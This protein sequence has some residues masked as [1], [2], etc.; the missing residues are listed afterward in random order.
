MYR[1]RSLI[2]LVVLLGT[3]PLGADNGAIAVAPV[4]RGLQID[5]DLAD[6]PNDRP[7]IRIAH[8][9][10]GD[11]LRAG[12]SPDLEA[13]ASLA[14]DPDLGVLYVGVQVIDDSIVLRASDQGWRSQDGCD[15][16][17]RTQHR[18]ADKPVSQFVLWGH[19]ADMFGALRTG[20]SI[21]QLRV[22]AQQSA[23]HRD[24]E[25]AIDL[26]AAGIDMYPNTII[27]F[28]IAI[29]D[30]D[31]DGSFT[32]LSWGR[33]TLK[34]SFPD[35]LGDLLLLAED[36]DL[37]PLTGSLSWQDLDEPVS[38]ALINVH[39]PPAIDINLLTDAE[40]NFDLVLPAG[41]YELIPVG[42]Q[43]D[44]R[45]ISLDADHPHLEVTVSP[46]T[47]QTTPALAPTPMP[48]GLGVRQGLWQTFG[49][50]DG[51]PSDVVHAI[52]QD[53]DGNIWLAT[54]RGLVKYDG[55]RFHTYDERHG[56]PTAS[57]LSL[58]EDREGDLWIGMGQGGVCRFDGR[59]F[60]TFT[61]RDGLVDNRV[62]TILQDQ[63]GGYWFGTGAGVS[64]Y[65]GHH[66]TNYTTRAGLVDNDISDLLQVDD[67][68]V[69]ISTGRLTGLS[70]GGGVSRFDGQTFSNLTVADG[71]PHARVLDLF[72]H[73]G[74]MWFATSAGPARMLPDGTI[75]TIGPDALQAQEIYSIVADDHENLW[76]T[77]GSVFGAG[78]GVV[79]FDGTGF[80]RFTSGDG[81]G[82]DRVLCSFVDREGFIWFGT[83]DGGVSRYDGTRMTIFTTEDGLP[84]NDV[85]KLMVDVDGS[86]W[87]ATSGGVARFNGRR[88]APTLT[89]DDGLHTNEIRQTFRADD[90]SLWLATGGFSLTGTG[91]GLVHIDSTG[92]R[93]LNRD[94]GLGSDFVT[95]L[96]QAENGTMWLATADGLIR[97]SAT[98]TVT[99]STQDGLPQNRLSSVLL[100]GQDVWITGRGIT[101]FSEGVFTTY[102]VA[103]GLPAEYWMPAIRDDSGTRWFGGDGSLSRLDGDDFRHYTP[104]DGLP[105]SDVM[106]LAT[107]PD[108]NLWL[109]TTT[110]VSRFD[111]RVFQ[112]LHRRDG[113]P[114]HEVRDVVVD[115]AG[116]AWIATAAGIARYR[117]H[118]GPLQLH[119]ADVVA[120]RGYGPVKSLALPVGQRFLAFEMGTDRLSNRSRTIVYRYRLL[121]HDPDWRQTRVPRVVYRDLWPGHFTFEV[122]AIDRDFNSSPMVR[123]AVQVQSAWHRDPTRWG[124]LLVLGLTLGGAATVGVRR[125]I[126]SRVERTRL[127]RRQMARYRVRDAVWRMQDASDIESVLRAVA[128]S[129]REM[130]VPFDFFGVNVLVDDSADTVEVYTMAATGTWHR[131]SSMVAPNI[132]KFWRG[133]RTVYRSDLDREDLYD[134]RP[135]ILSGLRSVVDIPFSR[136]TLAIS[137]SLPEA[138]SSADLTTLEELARVLEEGFHRLSDLESIQQR[139]REVG[140]AEKRLT[141][142]ERVR[143]VIWGLDD[144]RAPTDLVTVVNDCLHELGVEFDVC[145]VNVIESQ[146]PPRVR[147]YET[148]Q[149][150]SVEPTVEDGTPAARIIVDFW[151][152]QAVAY[153]RDL[154]DDDPHGEVAAHAA[155]GITDPPRSILDV[156]FSHGTL[157][158]NNRSANGFSEQ[159]QSNVTLLASL[160]SDGFRRLADLQ[161]LEAQSAAEKA[162]RLTAE[163]ANRTK[164]V[165]LANMSHEI[166]TPMNAILGYAQILQDD[167]RLDPGQRKGLNTIEKSGN[168]LL[169][170]INDV[171]DISKIE[172]GREEMHVVP[173][174]LSSLIETTA[175]MFEVRCRQKGLRWMLETDHLPEARVRGDE[176]KLR[177]VLINLL[178]NAVKFTTQGQILLRVMHVPDADSIRFEV[179]DTGRGIPAD[180]H[181]AIFEAFH[182][183]SA[184]VMEGGTGLG[185]AISRR[186]VAL[187]GGELL[188]ESEEG[189]GA[190]FRFELSLPT[191][192]GDGEMD[193]L[194]WDRVLRL[195][196]GQSVKALVVDDVDTNRDVLSQML[197]RIGVD[198]RMAASGQQALD[199]A[200][201]DI[202]DIVFMD[203]R[204]PEMGGVET[205]RHL[206]QRHGPR[207][208]KIIAVTASVLEHQ[209]EEYLREG[210]DGFV[211][212]PLSAG[213]VYAALHQHLGVILE[214]DE[215]DPR[216]SQDAG[217][218]D[219]RLP[220]RVS[221]ALQEAIESHSVTE[222]RRQ[223]EGL[224]H[225]GDA[226]RRLAAHLTDLSRQ[227]DLDAIEQV[228]ARLPA[229][230]STDDLADD[231]T[232]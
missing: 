37:L 63:E 67:G 101:R 6:W 162:A 211:D 49:A 146:L 139:Q 104:A 142:L 102:T 65:D 182:Q 1:L 26:Q 158:V 203:I 86:V 133:G 103:D 75:E 184:G 227:Y 210:F 231:A 84:H 220:A 217:W 9:E 230:D 161:T 194:N 60:T 64:R 140:A 14:Y 172:A 190:R 61:T 112:S 28:D 193:A 180:R 119:L 59:H 116:D 90:G 223:I 16:Y 99:F 92:L 50:I 183:E 201:S 163:Q 108:N 27:G 47:G 209:R 33:G 23:G 189:A 125:V 21:R 170:L 176:R 134:E 212:K 126:L 213:R 166:R 79:R 44:A 114:H 10:H 95:D 143:E 41:D 118:K 8:S 93:V 130:D 179:S 185:L 135:G 35:R 208:M 18:R 131:R 89:T 117:S 83:R 141:S 195:G 218:E 25:F 138:F 56:L 202:P 153:R 206:L 7:R 216:A 22:K 36:D 45:R 164:S 98:D 171:L 224:V 122:E 169:G 160:L 123:V 178:G 219:L 214:F 3:L 148:R 168:H 40:G 156:P 136:G 70:G 215:P 144:A 13:E 113:L 205:R 82:G 111:G 150:E 137:S 198:V 149:G 57:V 132:L 107:D 226:G 30:A 11:P 229:D 228:L 105:S 207:S 187:M 4:L 197:S 17:I 24:Y 147:C 12:T 55:E 100:D 58:L 121:G 91:Q 96:A 38:G 15:I 173:F 192:D 77:T 88:F 2:L 5:G 124:P 157:A 225:F 68:S 177:Q 128:E 151:R 199:R 80:R 69:W 191:T 154:Q 204:M 106:A 34:A 43:A 115:T 145:G 175:D 159:D 129:M 71:L 66:F 174:D 167:E 78:H 31:D 87:A 74:Q 48:A 109:A 81:L 19:H 29:N 72:S 76:F 155:M 97:L 181:E 232:H 222:L 120:D 85:R 200:E 46:P 39:R 54:D 53:R 110:G 42:R 186:Y 62:R 52:T 73:A 94:N 32:W 127:Q 51:L 188:L 152:R 196:A 20:D 165:F 221:Q